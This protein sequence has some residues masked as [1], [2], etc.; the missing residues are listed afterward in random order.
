MINTS[1]TQFIVTNQRMLKR[2]NGVTPIA[3]FDSSGMPVT[4]PSCKADEA[5]KKEFAALKG[6]ITKLEN[7]ISK[8]EHKASKEKE[9]EK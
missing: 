3:L 1:A 6:R 9:K 2:S 7:R 5:S 8:L 4:I